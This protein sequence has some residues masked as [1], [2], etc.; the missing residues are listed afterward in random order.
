M[1]IARHPSQKRIYIGD[2]DHLKKP[3]SIKH[4]LKEWSY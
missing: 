3:F 4:L 2:G 1:M